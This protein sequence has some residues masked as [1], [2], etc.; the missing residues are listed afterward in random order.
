MHW[1]M[2]GYNRNGGH[3]F[4][5]VESDTEPKDTRDTDEPMS[6]QHWCLGKA[7]PKHVKKYGI[8]RV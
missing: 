4:W 7:A 6:C 1:L 3:Y 2:C 8:I 5:V